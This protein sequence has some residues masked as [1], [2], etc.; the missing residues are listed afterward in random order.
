MRPNCL[1]ALHA[2]GWLLVC[3]LFGS[4]LAVSQT[5]HPQT[6]NSGFNV[7]PPKDEVIGKDAAAQP[8]PKS[9]ASSPNRTVGPQQDGSIVASDNQTLTPAGKIVALGAPVRAK[10]IALNPNETTHSA[11]VLLMG[12]PQPIVVFNTATGQVLQRFIPED[13]TAASRQRQERRFFHWHHVFR[14][15]LEAALQPRQ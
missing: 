12:S 10:A 13:A 4:G 11:A 6:G 3:M 2:L 14:R 7:T 1:L 8:A 9:Q 15:R 5:P